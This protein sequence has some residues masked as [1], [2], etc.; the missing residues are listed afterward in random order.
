MN[1]EKMNVESLQFRLYNVVDP[2]SIFN[3]QGLSFNVFIDSPSDGRLV[4]ID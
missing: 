2:N 1:K 4:R 3:I